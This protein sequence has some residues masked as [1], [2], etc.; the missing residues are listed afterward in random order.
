MFLSYS[1]T[2]A[3]EDLCSDCWRNPPLG[4]VWFQ[5]WDHLNAINDGTDTHTQSAASTLIRNVRNMGFR[6]KSNRLVSA[7]VASH[8]A[9]ATIDTH[10][11]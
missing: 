11:L 2:Q 4:F 3:S 7:V 9:F 8:I 1:S 5:L 6:V 10:V